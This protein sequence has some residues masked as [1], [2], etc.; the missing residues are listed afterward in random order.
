MGPPA[1]LLGLLGGIP[2]L[3][4]VWRGSGEEM[5]RSI[6]QLSEGDGE[7]CGQAPEVHVGV[8]KADG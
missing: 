1:T 3:I 6:K 4:V 8:A 7:S 5:G 2:P